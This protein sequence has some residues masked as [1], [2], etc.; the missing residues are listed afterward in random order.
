MGGA[1]AG[2]V[3]AGMEEAGFTEA[4]IAKAAFADAAALAEAAAAA[5][6]LRRRREGS[7]EWRGQGGMNRRKVWGQ[8]GQEK[9]S[10]PCDLQVAWLINFN[11]PRWIPSTDSKSCLSDMRMGQEPAVV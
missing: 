11:F 9:E 10:C 8:R 5:S 6:S 1:H 4:L 2:C 7:T 3:G